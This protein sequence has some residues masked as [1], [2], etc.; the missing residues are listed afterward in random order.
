MLGKLRHKPDVGPSGC[1]HPLARPQGSYFLK[2][3]HRSSSTSTDLSPHAARTGIHLQIQSSSPA[4]LAPL[5]IPATAVALIP[6]TLKSTFPTQIFLLEDI[7]ASLP[8][9]HIT[10]SH[11]A[12][13]KSNLM[14]L[15]QKLVPRKHPYT[16]PY[17]RLPTI[18]YSQPPVGSFLYYFI[19]S[20]ISTH[21]ATKMPDTLLS[22]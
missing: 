20:I 12:H 11:W 9:E 22:Y 4:L 3:V 14:S 21:T 19:K 5:E 16:C 1:S 10:S 6:V 15:F 2:R 7:P 18:P 13:P 17:P 8:K